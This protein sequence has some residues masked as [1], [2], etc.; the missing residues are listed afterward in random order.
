MLPIK[1]LIANI[2]LAIGLTAFVTAARAESP[3]LDGTYTL[4]AKASDD[5][6]KVIEATIANMSFVVR[7]FARGQFEDRHPA[8]PRIKIAHNDTEVIVTLGDSSPMHLPINGQTAQWKREDGE[9]LDMTGQWKSNH[10]IQVIKR[11]K[12]QRT[13][14]FSL[15]STGNTLTLNVDFFQQGGYMDKPMLYRLVYRRIESK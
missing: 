12:W 9:M 11:D 13:N 7:S 5:M 2:T 1:S 4:D 15:D 6:D 14:D 3:T 8:Y 10:L